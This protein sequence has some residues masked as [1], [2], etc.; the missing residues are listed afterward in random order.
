MG[1]TFTLGGDQISYRGKIGPSR[2]L[3]QVNHLIKS[4]VR[5]GRGAKKIAKLRG[6]KNCA[7]KF[8][9]KKSTENFGAGNIWGL[10][11]KKSGN[12]WGIFRTPNFSTRN[13][14]ASKIFPPVKK[15]WAAARK[16]KLLGLWCFRENFL[17]QGAMR[18]ALNETLDWADT[19]PL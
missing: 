3:S 4:E 13:Y 11:P 17:L 9:P 5:K 10:S 8:R 12:I 1:L 15:F 19:P 2:T 14:S 18:G 16:K 7:K 6:T